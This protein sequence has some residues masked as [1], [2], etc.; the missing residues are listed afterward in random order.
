MEA[1][2]HHPSLH[3][4]YLRQ[5]EQLNAII[6]YVRKAGLRALSAYQQDKFLSLTARQLMMLAAVQRQR[7]VGGS[8]LSTL[9]REVHMSISA[10][11]HLVDTLVE[12]RLLVRGT[13]EE[14]R[15]SLNITL[16]SNGQKCIDIVS[17]GMLAAIEE[18]TADFTPE[19]NALRLKMIDTLYRKAYPTA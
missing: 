9:A 15:R 17:K 3:D 13:H 1:M 6:D 11:S 8:T 7:K 4:T 16:S 14:D 19:E 18:L 10:A 2:E 12:H 5:V